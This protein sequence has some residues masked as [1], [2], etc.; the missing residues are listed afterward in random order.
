MNIKSNMHVV[1]LKGGYGSERE[2]SLKSGDACSK[3]LKENGF[4]VSELDFNQTFATE[5]TNLKPDVCFNALHGQYGEDGN[6]QGLLNILKIP[7][8]HSGVTTSSI[9]MNKIHFKR[10][11]TKATQDSNNPIYFPKS[12]QIDDGKRL[13]VKNHQGPYV[14]KPING[15]SSVGVHLI[16]DNLEAPL[17]KL[18][19]DEYLMAEALVG[20]RE[21]TVTVLRNKPLCV[22]EIKTGK[23]NDFYNY[24][25]KYVSGGSYHEIPAQIPDII[26]HRAMNWALKA[27]QIIGCRGISRSD[28]RYDPNQNKLFMLEINTQPGMT[29]TSLAPEQ[30]A[31]CNI[32]MA[33]MVRI[34]IEEAIYEC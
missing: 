10:I 30:G 23:N 8:T 9:A 20:S 25:A 32:N 12:L 13:S 22:T 21:L 7:Y 17:K 29:E 11:I 24:D 19:S 33:K 1:L 27:H 3:A 18:W 15:G 31:F 28:F 34:L 14:I 4:K 16:K 5:L 26:S 2:I 6:I